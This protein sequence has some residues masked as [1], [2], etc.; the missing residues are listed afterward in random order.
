MGRRKGSMKTY[1]SS[2]AYVSWAGL[3][4]SQAIRCTI[5]GTWHLYI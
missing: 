3:R 2:F 5:L 1:F 4:G